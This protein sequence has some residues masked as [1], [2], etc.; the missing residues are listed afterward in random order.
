M[1]LNAE[2]PLVDGSCSNASRILKWRSKAV[3]LCALFS[4]SA[5]L[6]SF[7]VTEDIVFIAFAII[8]SILTAIRFFELFQCEKNSAL[9]SKD[10]DMPLPAIRCGLNFV[11]TSAALGALCFYSIYIS[12][13]MFPVTASLVVAVASAIPLLL[14]SYLNLLLIIC[15][16]VVVA[17]P[18]AI[19]LILLGTVS[20]LS[21]LFLEALYVTGVIWLAK[22][23]RI[24]SIAKLKLKKVINNKA[25]RL[26]AALNTM[27]QGVVLFDP[28][29]NV[30]LINAH[31][32]QLLNMKQHRLLGRSYAVI[33][34]YCVLSGLF[35]A[36]SYLNIR[37]R[38]EG[39]LNG[40]RKQ[41]ILQLSA[42]RYIECTATLNV[43]GNVTLLIGDVTSRI[44]AEEQ[45]QYMAHY[46]ALTNLPNR[47]Y[48]DRLIKSVRMNNEGT[49][50]E[51]LIVID[52][53]QLKRINEAYGHLCGDAVL[54]AFSRRLTE[55]DKK[56]FIASRFG[57]D[58]FV[59]YVK[60]SRSEPDVTNILNKVFQSITGNY[61]I[62]HIKLDVDICAGVVVSSVKQTLNDLHMKAGLALA[63]AKA[64][65]E[66]LW[67]IYDECMNEAYHKN[68]RLREDLKKAV[69]ANALEVHYQPIV[70]SRSLRV[71]AYE[72]LARWNHPE[73]GYIS[74]AD[75]IPLAEEIGLVSQITEKVLLRACEDCTFWP[76]H[77]NVSV[78]LSVIDLENDKVIEAVQQAL[79]LSHLEAHRLELE[80]TE[81]AVI[82]DQD[83]AVPILERLRT[84]NVSIALDDFGTGYSSLSYLNV[85]PLTKIKIDRAFVSKITVNNRSMMLLRGIAH[86][87]RELGLG[88]TV[89]GIETEEQLA[90]IRR[91]GV[92]DLLQGFILGRPCPADQIVYNDRQTLQ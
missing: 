51:L 79:K 25:E 27:P 54:Q 74:P 32:M 22:M 30:I 13:D 45:I 52:I 91:S 35:P 64:S 89:E 84:L 6:L 75:F 15:C 88:V 73:L 90:I 43:D 11:L 81:S 61:N 59:I 76:D 16:I 20:S 8:F 17:L 26:D 44:E 37:S 70:S 65:Q 38:I 53:Q 36:D 14:G 50:W 77:I 7:A 40:Q 9:I 78:N 28:D 66:Q 55:I 29:Y 69:E 56:R 1:L 39:L 33:T 92:A 2:K 86:L 62:S 83:R 31:A 60:P 48:F 24:S 23:L 49:A 46:D 57:S 58:E 10:T 67:V 68:K 12:Q 87:S 72:A 4:I 19:A 85:L 71:V 21:L 41:D 18:I 47:S 34:R 5:S 80:V 42:G 3:L 82:R 63:E